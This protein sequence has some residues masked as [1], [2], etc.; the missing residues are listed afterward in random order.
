MTADLA[1]DLD[2]P[3][4]P[5]ACA[6]ARRS[7]GQDLTGIVDAKRISELV[8]V[9]S[10]LVGNAVEHG[11]GGIR[12][13]LRVTGGKVTGEVVDG[14]HGFEHQVRA[15]G[16]DDVR[17]RGLLIVERL[18]SRWGVHEGTTHVWFEIDAGASEGEQR[19][20]L[21]VSERPPELPPSG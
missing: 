14:G 2:L 13:R 20:V 11:R 16:P 9:V 5:S 8:L 17:G 6:I 15:A 10:E 4:D 18:T 12:L 1:I 7:V 3:R 21:G 19:P